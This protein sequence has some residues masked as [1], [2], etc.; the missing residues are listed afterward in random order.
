MP[1]SPRLGTFRLRSPRKLFEKKKAKSKEAKTSAQ[2]AEK[3]CADR[4]AKKAR[5]DRDAKARANRDVKKAHADRAAKAAMAAERAMVAE[6]A[7]A[8]HEA[9]AAT[10]AAK[11]KAAKVAKKVKQD[12]K[13]DDRF[14]KHLADQGVHIKNIDGDGNCFYKAVGAQTGIDHLKLRTDSMNMLKENRSRF[15]PFLEGC[16]TKENQKKA[17]KTHVT[18][19]KR[20]TLPIFLVLFIQYFHLELLT[21]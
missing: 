19:G 20:N 2:D 7:R 5:A 1:P 16:D 18:R 14:I 12:L 9:K 13:D 8:D 15:L 17:F 21:S 11:A 10:R 6:K 3:A 4:D